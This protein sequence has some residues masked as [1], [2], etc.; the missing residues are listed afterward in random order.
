MNMISA[1]FF[2]VVFYALIKLFS[3]KPRF[4]DSSIVRSDEYISRL[5][6]IHSGTIT[7]NPL[8]LRGWEGEMETLFLIEAV[9]KGI[10]YW[11]VGVNFHGR[12]SEFDI[13]V[14][15]PHGV[16]HIEVKTY[17]GTYSPANNQ[18]AKNPNDWK[19]VNTFSGEVRES[20]SPVSQ[21]LRAKKI[22][23]DRKSV[24]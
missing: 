11:N 2:G 24:V 18:P 6:S 3:G 14:L 8:R 7:A 21:A 10:V 16:I 9:G 13:L 19:K 5:K 12:K 1:L 15:C 4:T 20:W 22:L 23:S 17:S